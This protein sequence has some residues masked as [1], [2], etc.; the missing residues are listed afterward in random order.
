M[1]ILLF[2]AFMN[3]DYHND[4]SYS[5]YLTSVPTLERR[6]IYATSN[7]LLWQIEDAYP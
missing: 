1:A 6:V 5:V 3:K 7:C 2:R 4:I